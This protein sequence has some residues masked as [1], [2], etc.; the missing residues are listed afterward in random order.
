MQ[1]EKNVILLKGFL[2]SYAEESLSPQSYMETHLTYW[3]SS[4]P[5]CWLSNFSTST[6][7]H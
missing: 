7:E 3:L 6:G 1:I 2:H 4:E 5:E